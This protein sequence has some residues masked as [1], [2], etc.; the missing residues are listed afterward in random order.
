M[1]K[2]LGFMVLTLGFA[3]SALAMGPPPPGSAPE[4]DPNSAISALALVSGAL[5]V[6]RGRRK[7]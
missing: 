2:I 5:L 6:I 7:A 1:K 4:I 3:V